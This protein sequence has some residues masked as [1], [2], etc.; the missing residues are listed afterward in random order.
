MVPLLYK[1]FYL[2]FKSFKHL[3]TPESNA[4]QSVSTSKYLCAR[5]LLLHWDL[6]SSWKHKWCWSS[7]RGDILVS[8]TGS[9]LAWHWH[10]KLSADK[11]IKKD[12][13]HLDKQPL[14]HTLTIIAFFFF[15]ILV[16]HLKI[17]TYCVDAL[18]NFQ[19]TVC[20]SS[21]YC[22]TFKRKIGSTSSHLH[23]SP[24]FSS[25]SSA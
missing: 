17:G 7:G 9:I 23:V 13:P 19:L 6:T 10:N 3:H 11:F 2:L 14:R 5:P 8:A 21:K 16:P 24:F 12:D 22:S 4:T 18:Q 15:L 20:P 1:L 25:I